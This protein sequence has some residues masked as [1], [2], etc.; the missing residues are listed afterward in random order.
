[1]KL[2]R[3]FEHTTLPRAV[4]GSKRVFPMSYTQYD[5][6]TSWHLCLSFYYYLVFLWLRNLRTPLWKDAP[7]QQ[8]CCKP[9]LPWGQLLR[10]V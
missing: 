7:K 9:I 3:S 1:M 6:Y 10:V 5:H 8:S 2:L 4:A